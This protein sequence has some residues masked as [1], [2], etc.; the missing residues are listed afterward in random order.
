MTTQDVAVVV[1]VVVLVV[2]V[3]VVAMVATVDKK[4]IVIRTQKVFAKIVVANG[5]NVNSINITLN[6]NK[7]GNILSQN[8]RNKSYW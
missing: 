6:F 4:A 5:S 3:V 8:N 2:V 1:V 7:S